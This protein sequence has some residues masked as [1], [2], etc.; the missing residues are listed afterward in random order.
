MVGIAC[1]GRYRMAVD[2]DGAVG[3]A[4]VREGKVRL[5]ERV[6]L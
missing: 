6:R 4:H 1:G 5:A 2:V 3:P